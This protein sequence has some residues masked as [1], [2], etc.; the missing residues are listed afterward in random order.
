[1]SI[2]I[3]T[4]ELTRWEKRLL[5][6]IRDTAPRSYNKILRKAGNLMRKNVRALTP[7]KTGKLKKSYRIKKISKDEINVYSKAPHAHLIEDGHKIVVGGKLGRGGRVVGFVPGKH[8]FRRG[9]EK[10]EQQLPPLLKE[11]V[12]EIGRELGMDVSG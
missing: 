3:D 6:V 1:M 2:E 9:F 12:R 11:L 5:T 10:T 8:Y 4:D 7:R